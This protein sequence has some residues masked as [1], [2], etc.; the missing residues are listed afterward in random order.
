M[1]SAEATDPNGDPVTAPRVAPLPREEW[2]PEAREVFGYWEGDEARENGSRSNT[3]MT[4]ANHPKLAI[5][6]LDFGKYFMLDSTLTPRQQKLVVL[7]VAHRYGSTYQWTHNAFGA[8]QVGITDA[9]IDG[10]RIGPQASVWSHADAMLLRTID[11]ACAGGQFDDGTWSDLTAVFDRRQL[12]DIIQAAGY[13][14]TVAW[15]LVA[16]RVQVEPDFAAF[17]KNRAKVDETGP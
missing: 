1:S 5:A 6:S 3:M 7:R 8:K 17:S 12:M 4:L 16:L 14:S 10:V 15:T 11:G 13:F 9:E 2:T